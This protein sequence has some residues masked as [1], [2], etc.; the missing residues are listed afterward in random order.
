M[1]SMVQRVV[2]QAQE[3]NLTN[4]ITLA[5]NASQ[6]DIIQNQLGER[7]S[8]VK[9]PERRNTFPAIALAA[10]YLKLKKEC[11]DDEVVVIMPCDPLQVE[12]PYHSPYGGMCGEKHSRPRADGYQTYYPSAKYGYAYALLKEKSI[13]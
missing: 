13:R 8:V 11:E 2:R 3:A 1:E 6:L 4:D 9:E 12:S 5:T 7:V 10:S